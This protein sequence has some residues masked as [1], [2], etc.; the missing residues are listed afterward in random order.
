MFNAPVVQRIE[1][2]PPELEVWV[3]FPPGVLE[4]L[5]VRSQTEEVKENFTV[6]YSQLSMRIF[7]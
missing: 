1:R 5:K 6:V 2:E 7:I 4:T 3:R